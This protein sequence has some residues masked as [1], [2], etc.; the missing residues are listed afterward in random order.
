[1][2]FAPPPPPFKENVINNLIYK[3]T[4][5]FIDIAVK[6]FEDWICALTDLYTVKCLIGLKGILK[7]FSVTPCTLSSTTMS[8]R[9]LPFNT[10]RLLV[11]VEQKLLKYSSKTKS[12]V[13]RW[14]QCYI[15]QWRRIPS[16]R[17]KMSREDPSFQHL[18]S[19]QNSPNWNKQENWELRSLWRK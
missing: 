8:S 19:D 13:T 6:Y 5:I 4:T 16:P 17:E 12:T 3:S 9:S 14:Q 1:M 11:H 2:N 15:L 10:S 18:I 7:N